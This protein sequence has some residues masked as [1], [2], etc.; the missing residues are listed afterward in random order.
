MYI[1]F[2]LPNYILLTLSY[3]IHV[4]QK[5]CH[6]ECYQ[7]LKHDFFI[8]VRD[9]KHFSSNEDILLKNLLFFTHIF[10]LLYLINSINNK[11][12]YLK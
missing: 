12:L 2:R 7:S 4:P 8:L 5:I 6:Y 9:T 3:L 11:I 10:F 1:T